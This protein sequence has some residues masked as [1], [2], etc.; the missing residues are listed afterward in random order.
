MHRQL[1]HFLF[2]EHVEELAEAIAELEK[3]TT[4]TNVHTTSTER[5]GIL[6]GIRNCGYFSDCMCIRGT[7]KEQ[8]Q[9]MRVIT[10]PL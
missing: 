6:G 3:T 2:Y 7:Q 4:Y 1:L 9:V 10:K 5:T 8:E